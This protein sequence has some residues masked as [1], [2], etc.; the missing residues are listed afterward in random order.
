MPP[1]DAEFL[2]LSTA[3][4]WGLTPD[5][6]RCETVDCRARMMVHEIISGKREGY[7]SDE[8]EKAAKKKGGDKGEP[9]RVDPLLRLM[10]SRIGR[11]K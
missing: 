1:A 7:Y 6:W 9:E 11:Q 2:E 3:K 4:A 5:E 10:E 8:S